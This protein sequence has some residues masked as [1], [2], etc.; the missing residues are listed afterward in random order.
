M[1]DADCL[2]NSPNWLAEIAGS[3]QDETEIVL[4]Y[5]PYFKQNGFLNKLIRFETTHT[6]MSYLSYAL[7]R[8]AYMG[9]GRNLSYTKSL[10]FKGKGF[11][12]HM[13]VKS[14]DDD[15]FVNHNATRRNV[16]ITIHPDTQVHSE[17]KDTWTGYY[18]QKA[19][20]SGAS[21]LYKRK[22]KAMLATQLISSFLF[23]LWLPICVIIYP[24]YWYYAVVAYALRLLCQLIVFRS[25]YRK[26]GVKDILFW[27]PILDIVYYFYICINGL[28]NRNKKQKSW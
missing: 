10:F 1:T 26:L 25:V 24:A 11:N 7:K 28:F 23:Y 2:P 21:T 6:A 8:N 3:Y 14:G 13:H 16:R 15:L 5:S 27:L 9:V 22:H 17:P 20:H 19:R 12:A 18:R 4:G